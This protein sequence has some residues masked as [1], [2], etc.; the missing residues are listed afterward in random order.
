M[1]SGMPTS[2]PEE[3]NA[4]RLDEI[5]DAVLDLPAGERPRFLDEACGSDSKLRAHVDLAGNVANLIARYR[6]PAQSTPNTLTVRGRSVK[7][8]L[9]VG[10]MCNGQREGEVR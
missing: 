7:W 3:P 6:N 2:L 4:D 5:L 10:A 8:T 1:A 9:N